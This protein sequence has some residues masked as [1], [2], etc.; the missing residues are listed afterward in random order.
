MTAIAA[1]APPETE[2]AA[3]HMLPNPTGSLAY[4]GGYLFGKTFWS[5]T[6]HGVVFKVNASTGDETI[7]YTFAQRDG[8]P[9]NLMYHAGKLYEVTSGGGGGHGSIMSIDPNTGAAKRLYKFTGGTDGENPTGLI[10]HKGAFYGTTAGTGTD[11][12]TLFKF[13][14]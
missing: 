6:G 1:C 14:P 3:L 5:D 13:I 8:F 11:G 9:G 12:G 2:N 10:F 7:L 4:N